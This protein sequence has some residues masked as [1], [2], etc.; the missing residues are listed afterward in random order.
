VRPEVR[1]VVL[2]VTESGARYSSLLMS[3]HVLVMNTDRCTCTL[4]RRTCHH[5]GYGEVRFNVTGPDPPPSS[6][7]TLHGALNFL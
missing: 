6:Q 5:G 1:L 7:S 3:L 4:V 2:L